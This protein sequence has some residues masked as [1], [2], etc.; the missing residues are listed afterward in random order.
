MIVKT[1][2]RKVSVKRWMGGKKRHW[3]LPN[4]E[5]PMPNAQCLLRNT[6]PGHIRD[7]QLVHD[8]NKG[9]IGTGAVWLNN[10]KKIMGIAEDGF[11]LLSFSQQS[12]PEFMAGIKVQG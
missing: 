8:I 7:H 3:A 6:I 10:H 5:C 11:D 1:I 12:G 9:L 2:L 4:A